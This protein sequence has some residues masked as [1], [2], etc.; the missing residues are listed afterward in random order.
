[1]FL[2]Q[3]KVAKNSLV[4]G[5]M[6]IESDSMGIML[7]IRNVQLVEEI[8]DKETPLSQHMATKELKPQLRKEEQLK[9]K[10]APKNIEEKPAKSQVNI[11]VLCYK[12]QLDLYGG[13][14][15]RNTS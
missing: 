8:F 7:G 13:N 10:P 3:V 15:S 2:L 14:F 6:D 11:A 1:M 12:Y 9:T 5:D 4:D